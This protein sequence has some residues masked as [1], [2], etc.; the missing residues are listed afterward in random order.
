MKFVAA[1]LIFAAAFLALFEQ[2]KSKPNVIIMVVAFVLF[3][4][5]IMR[6]FSKVPSKYIKDNEQDNNHV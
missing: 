5:G 3:M 6:L 1:L 4:F 2:S